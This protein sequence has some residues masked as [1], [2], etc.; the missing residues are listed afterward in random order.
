MK[1]LARHCFATLLLASV[2]APAALAD[3]PRRHRQPVPDGGS[4]IA[5]LTLGLV[6]VAGAIVARRRSVS[7]SA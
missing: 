6:T 5:F 7:Q 1:S 2:L 4:S 3:A